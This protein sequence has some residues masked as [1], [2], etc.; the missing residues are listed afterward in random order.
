MQCHPN[1]E[2]HER[3]CKVDNDFTL[4]LLFLSQKTYSRKT[5]QK[6]FYFYNHVCMHA[7]ICLLMSVSS[8]EI[9]A[10]AAGGGG[11]GRREEIPLRT[12]PV[13]ICQM[14]EAMNKLTG[15]SPTSLASTHVGHLSQGSYTV[16]ISLV[17]GVLLSTERPFRA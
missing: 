6:S 8:T 4:C 7:C 10:W 13:D 3:K 2:K 5:Y 12:R 17:I 1:I 16:L 15:W 11:L 9:Q 14:N